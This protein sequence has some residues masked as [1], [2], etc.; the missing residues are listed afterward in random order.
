MRASQQNG[1]AERMNTLLN[2]VRCMLSDSDLPKNVL[3]RNKKYNK[4]FSAFVP[5]INFKHENKYGN[6]VRFP[7]QKLKECLGVLVMHM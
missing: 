7:L 3:G 6:V 1:L 5:F 4:L 2:K